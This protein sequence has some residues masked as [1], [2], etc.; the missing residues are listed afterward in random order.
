M[1]LS[2]NNFICCKKK[3]VIILL[4][5]LSDESVISDVATVLDYQITKSLFFSPVQLLLK[6]TMEGT[7]IYLFFFPQKKQWYMKGSDN[8]HVTLG[9]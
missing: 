1:P 6:S 4:F 3:I 2:S 8:V 9:I 5:T 7:N